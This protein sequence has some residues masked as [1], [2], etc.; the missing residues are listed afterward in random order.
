MSCVLTALRSGLSQA[1]DTI[2]RWGVPSGLMA[3]PLQETSASEALR[4][5]A[6]RSRYRSP[7][8]Q[9]DGV[10]QAW[11]VVLIAVLLTLAVALTVSLLGTDLP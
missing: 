6:A 2:H 9:R 5:A 10:V 3:N 1:L 4:S 8:V 7:S 11:A